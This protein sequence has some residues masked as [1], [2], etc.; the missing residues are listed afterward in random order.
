MVD[1][2]L[3]GKYGGTNFCT[4]FAAEGRY[5]FMGTFRMGYAELVI[6]LSAMLQYISKLS[7]PPPECVS[8]PFL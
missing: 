6:S 4:T 2:R 7:M 1:L 5:S 3:F 8:Q